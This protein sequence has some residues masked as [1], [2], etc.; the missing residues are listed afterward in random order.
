MNKAMLKK[1]LNESMF[2]SKGLWMMV[3]VSVILSALL[4]VVANIKEGAAMAQSDILQYAIKAVMFMTIMVSMVLGGSCFVSE[5]EGHTMESLLLTP[6]SKFSLTLS[7]YTS[8]VI[9]GAI[10]YL[11]SVPYIIAISYGSGLAVRALLICLLNGGLLLLAFSAIAVSFSILTDSSKTA[12]LVSG[13]LLVVLMF[14]AFAQGILKQS[15]IGRTFLAMDP[16]ANCFNL[17]TPLLSDVAS[18]GTVTQYIWP[19]VIF[20]ALCI[21]LLVW[22]SKRISLKGEK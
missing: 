17:M 1:E 21:A 10:L 20:A 19:Q 11:V 8:A 5:R 12:I 18:I 3:A 2:E 9:L 22:S 7:K 6:V 14:P 16:L 13:L 15:L 4:I